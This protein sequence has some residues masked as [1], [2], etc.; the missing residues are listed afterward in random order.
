MK[1]NTLKGWVILHPKET[2]TQYAK[3]AM[4]PLKYACAQEAHAELA[5][6]FYRN[7][8]SRK[9]PGRATREKWREKFRPH[10]TMVRATLS[11]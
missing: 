10:C 6:F 8:N 4:C 9:I 3:R 5:Y 2:K 7:W 1:N 11:W